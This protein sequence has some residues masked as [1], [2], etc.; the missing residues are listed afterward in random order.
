MGEKRVKVYRLTTCYRCDLVGEF[1]K[2]NG[3]EFE[4]ITVDQLQGEE[5]ERA[6]AEAYRLSRQRSFP[7]TDAGT[8]VIIG[9]DEEKLRQL[10]PESGGKTKPSGPII[11]QKIEPTA[12]LEELKSWLERTALS[13]QYIVNPDKRIVDSILKGL[14]VNEKRF[15]YK[16]CPCRLA[17]GKYQL[18]C[19]I[20]CPCTYCDWDLDTYGRCFCGLFV[21]E[22]YLEKDATLPEY[23]I[24]TRERKDE[25]RITTP[26]SEAGIEADIIL[27]SYIKLV[28]YTLSAADRE[29]V[30]KGFLRLAGAL[31]IKEEAI[32]WL[33][34]RAFAKKT[35]ERGDTVLLRMEQGMEVYAYQVWFSSHEP[36]SLSRYISYLELMDFS[37][38]RNQLFEADV[39]LFHDPPPQ[40]TMDALLPPKKRV[41][42]KI[43]NGK[44]NVFAHFEG[45]GIGKDRYVL[46]RQ[47]PEVSSKKIERIVDDT[48]RLENCYY[49][50]RSERQRYILASDKLG[51]LESRIVA[52]MGIITIN[53][54]NA[55]HDTLKGWLHG[56]STDFAEVSGT[57]EDL[58][59][60]ST[61]TLSR[62]ELMR[63][64]FRVWQEESAG[65]SHL[66]SHFMLLNIEGLGD[67]YHRL[68]QRID[69][70]RKEMMDIITMLRTKIDLITQEQS[71]ELQRSVDETTKTQVRLQ[72]TVE[73]L[74]VIVLAYYMT[75]L[76]KIVFDTVEKKDLLPY[77]SYTM[78]AIFIPV[79]ILGSL[80][81]T[82]KARK[83]IGWV[84]D[85][86]AK[87]K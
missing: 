57:A 16:S 21:T 36:T 71:L 45:D 67:D 55:G 13:H 69:G 87:G 86:F 59:H 19:D 42:S 68:S 2:R 54:A 80:F 74:S 9:F 30:K 64:I 72:H 32:R 75:A 38:H 35:S 48:G 78:T 1:L 43:Y 63:N 66:L 20:V 49:L 12:S 83:W 58:R 7:V 27:N 47:G 23:K 76:A 65:E 18:D 39:Y 56:L 33:E 31:D 79:A 28:G 6:I 53:L 70:I 46:I 5:Q 34:N 60:H 41:G 24:D 61:D 40:S 52:K 73:G 10:I 44:M 29:V 25:G 82:G 8:S 3:I 85:K 26:L 14:S 4:S 50:L 22:R 81:L 15:G 51:E 84:I 11:G 17:A 77:S 37:E 62:R